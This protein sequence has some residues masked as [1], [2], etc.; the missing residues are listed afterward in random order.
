MILAS[1]DVL[2]NATFRNEG[3]QTT[4]LL[5]SFLVNKLPLLLATLSTQ[6]FPPLTV[7]Y[8]ITEALSQVDTNAF[9]TF[10]AT[11]DDSSNS[12]NMFGDSVRQDFCFACCLHGLILEE[13]LERFVGDAPMQTL[14]TGGRYTK[15][16]LVQQ[17]LSDPEKPESLIDELERMDG[18][19]GAASQ[20]V[21]DVCLL[22]IS[23]LQDIHP[24]TDV[25]QVIGNLCH[26]KETMSLKTLC[27]QLARKP[28]SLD[29]MLLF[30]KPATILLPICNLLDCWRYEED[31]GEYQPVYEEFGAILLLV[32]AITHRYNLSPLEIGCTSS[33]SFVAR[34]L[35]K[36]AVSR[37]LDQLSEVE[38]GHLDGWTRGLF[39]AD[40]SGLGDELMSSCPP[41][42]FYMLVPTLFQQIVLA[43][44]THNLSDDLLKGGLECKSSPHLN[45]RKLIPTR[46]TPGQ[47]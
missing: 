39:A 8:C 18:N 11:F 1:F 34:L 40:G 32:L 47:I 30:N 19:V 22:F 29:V 9:P 21:A 41:Q 17:C 38:L 6:L 25:A 14:P 7:E 31:Q 27:S 46:L 13:N 15:E 10:S 20:A 12:D 3:M 35:Q 43:G 36:G 16:V 28:S 26:T 5:R 4:L 33:E 37:P 44:H 45:P 42:E 2:S 23:L 24:R